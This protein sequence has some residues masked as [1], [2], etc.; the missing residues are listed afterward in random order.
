MSPKELHE[1]LAEIVEVLANG[2]YDKLD[3]KF[4]C[5]KMSDTEVIG[6]LIIEKKQEEKAY[7]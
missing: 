2:N 3:I 1:A 6:Q 7:E 4:H 5:K